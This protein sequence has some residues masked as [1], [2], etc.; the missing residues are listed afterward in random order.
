MKILKNILIVSVLALSLKA[1][2]SNLKVEAINDFKEAS[3]NW[4]GNSE[5]AS[6]YS[7]R[8]QQKFALYDECKHNEEFEK[9]NNALQEVLMMLKEIKEM[10]EKSK[11]THE[12]LM[13][14]GY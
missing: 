11:P 1:D 14:T 4:N 12:E 7:I 10:K 9:V 6:Y 8:G 2:C 13:G 5:L 3:K